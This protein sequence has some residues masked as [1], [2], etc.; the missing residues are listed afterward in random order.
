M[1]E[2]LEKGGRRIG[3]VLKIRPVD[4]K[5]GRIIGVKLLPQ[6]SRSGTLIEIVS[7][8]IHSPAHPS[9][10]PQYLGKDRFTPTL[11]KSEGIRVKASEGE[12]VV[13]YFEPSATQNLKSSGFPAG[14]TTWQKSTPS[15]EFTHGGIQEFVILL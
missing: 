7:K 3:E 4:A 5:G 2:L 8:V 14:E 11:Q 10:T 1:L 15:F 12:D 6:A 9:T 13:L